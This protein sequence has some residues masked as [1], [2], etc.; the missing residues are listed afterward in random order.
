[1]YRNGNFSFVIDSHFQPFSMQEMLIP[2]TA[3]K[4]AFEKTEAAYDDL[5]QKADTFKYLAKVAEDNPDSRAA[6]IYKGYADELDKQAKDLAQNGLSMGNRQGLMGLKKRFQG[7]IGRLMQADA[8][9][10]QEQQLRRQMNAKDSSMLYA[11]DNLSIDSFLDG[12][13]PNLYGISGTE[14]YSR[15]AQAGKS[16]SSRIYNAG[17][18]GSTLGGYYRKWIETNGY[19]ADSINRFR[20]DA[21][22]IPELQQAANA[23]LKERGVLD[24]LSGVNLERARQSVLNGIIDGAV[25]QEKVNPVRD[26]GVMSAAEKDASAR[27]RASYELHKQ[28]FDMKK[29]AYEDERQLKYKFDEKGNIIGLNPDYATPNKNLTPEQQAMREQQKADYKQQ[30]VNAQKVKQARTLKDVDKAGYI[31]IFATVHPS[32]GS[33]KGLSI[34]EARKKGD[35]SNVEGWRSG[36]SGT[37]VPDLYID[38]TDAPLVKGSNKGFMPDL[39]QW[40]SGNVV[41]PNNGDFAYSDSELNGMQ[42]K[43]LSDEEYAK[44]PPAVLT[45]ITAEL[46]RH[47]Y[48]EGTPFEVME[49]VGKGGKT[50]YMTLVPKERQILMGE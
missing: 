7:E 3:Y 20:A 18:G 23:I 4:D 37:D 46:E 42:T 25:Y 19:N 44:L 14:L 35:Y 2:F 11:N 39:I 9:M 48:T 15:G 31:P 47:G 29:Q 41:S 33:S 30:M 32:H 16:A 28:E 17:D 24:N 8:A 27:S 36:V 1:M 6:Q 45:S 34:E 13:T 38:W 12:E 43:I 26:P 50:S 21:A 10:K 40:S 22:A 5:V 49:V